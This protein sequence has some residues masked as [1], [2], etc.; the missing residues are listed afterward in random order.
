[1]LPHD[2]LNTRQ[3]APGP[4]SL[5]LG[6]CSVLW[7]KQIEAMRVMLLGRLPEGIRA[8]QHKPDPVR[9]QARGGQ[10][11]VRPGLLARRAR[12]ASVPPAD[13]NKGALWLAQS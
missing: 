6:L 3:Q 4:C 1:M 12:A 10:R 5:L 7:E 9:R 2:G 8:A 13:G 11:Q